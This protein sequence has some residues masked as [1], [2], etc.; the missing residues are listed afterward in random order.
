ML[1]LFLQVSILHSYF[2]S[3]NVC[4]DHHYGSCA[5]LCYAQYQ[6]IDIKFFFSYILRYC[7]D[8]DADKAVYLFRFIL[9]REP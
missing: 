3:D 9:K 4:C 1:V 7:N 5:K 8:Q 6:G 2:F